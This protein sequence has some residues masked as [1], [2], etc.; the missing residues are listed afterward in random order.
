MTCST[1]S[2]LSTGSVQAGQALRL[3]SLAQGKQGRPVGFWILM[4]F[5]FFVFS[6]QCSQH[7]EHKERENY[8]PT[9]NK[10]NP[11]CR[12]HFL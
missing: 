10:E 6:P 4:L 9:D 11:A 12:S 5:C 3:V 1:H 7:T 8:A 2:L